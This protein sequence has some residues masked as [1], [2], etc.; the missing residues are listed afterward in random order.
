MAT[1]RRKRKR[2][3]RR[4]NSDRTTHSRLSFGSEHDPNVCRLLHFDITFEPIP[5]PLVEAMPPEDR[6]TF[7]SLETQVLDGDCD[8]DTVKMLE[9]LCDRHPHVP[10]IQNHMMIAYQAVGRYGDSRRL[11]KESYRRFPDYLFALTSYVRLCLLEGLMEEAESILGKKL[12]ICLMYPERPRFHV[13]EFMAYTGTIVEYLFR[14]GQF[15]AAQSNFQMLQQV[16]PD[17]PTTLQLERMMREIR[18]MALLSTL[19]NRLQGQRD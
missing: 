10:K 3:R 13:S 1:T 2:Q 12:H 7:R 4:R 6:E 11:I 19:L 17:H 18:P 5:D 15:E 8:A 9:E 14:K 16:N